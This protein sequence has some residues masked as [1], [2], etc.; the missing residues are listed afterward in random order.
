MKRLAVFGAGGHTNEFKELS[1]LD[2]DI[3]V[4]KEWVTDE[5]NNIEDFDPSIWKIIVCIGDSKD[6][7]KVVDKLPIGTEFFTYIH[8]TAIVGLN[9]SLG[10]GTYVGPY[11]II[12]TNAVIGKHALINRQVQISHDCIIGDFFSAM[13]GSTVSGNCTIGDTVYLGSNSS[14]RQKIKIHNNVKIGMGST[15]VNNIV[16]SGTYVGVPAKKKVKLSII[17]PCYNFEKYIEQAIDSTLSQYTDFDIEVI[18][19]DDKSTDNSY[20]LIKKYDGKIIHYRNDENLGPYNN[21]KKMLE[22]ANGK[23]I[24]YLDGD[25]YFIDTLKS[26]KQVDFL[27]SNPDYSMH[28]TGCFYGN[29]DGSQTEVQIHPLM[30]EVTTNELVNTNLVG[31]GRTFRNYRKIIKEWMKETYYLDWSFNVELSLMGKIKCENWPSGIYR[32][33]G[34]GMI[35]S[36]TNEEIYNLNNQC[37]EFISKRIEYHKNYDEYK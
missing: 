21:I 24:S 31:F 13:P 29:E 14:I 19:G 10:E 1:G 34:C 36:K 2:F 23:Y 17:I 11:C 9:V 18:V 16:N 12:T 6:R 35:T 30:E 33:T 25:D 27:E 5:F 20:E 32:I 3:F 37:I 26:Q 22:I 4:D 15:L 8:P 28:S 7:Q